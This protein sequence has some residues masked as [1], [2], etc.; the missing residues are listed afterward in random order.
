LRW[1]PFAAA[2][3]SVLVGNLPSLV[4]FLV[5]RRGDWPLLA[6]VPVLLSIA[7]YVTF[8]LEK[9]AANERS[10]ARALLRFEAPALGLVVIFLTGA[11]AIACLEPHETSASEFLVE[12]TGAVG[13]SL[14]LVGLPEAFLAGWCHAWKTGRLPLEL[15]RAVATPA[16]ELAPSPQAALPPSRID[17]SALFPLFQAPTGLTALVAAVWIAVQGERDWVVLPWTFL[18][19][20]PHLLV[21]A[22][23]TH[24][25]EV[26]RDRRRPRPAPA[27]GST[28]V[29]FVLPAWVIFQPAFLL[30]AWFCANFSL[31]SSASHPEV[32]FAVYG[33]LTGGFVVLVGL[34]LGALGFWSFARQRSAVQ[35]RE[36]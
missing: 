6:P 20:A 17:A 18:P 22:A 16:S 29:R 5:V 7:A 31:A 36:P 23:I 3:S 19:L 13:I 27:L 26:L 2:W 11:F 12:L 24:G 1:N 32:G 34:P 15:P 9:R 30:S 14:V 21:A 35:A 10:F 8:R 28:I 4:T 25:L 33:F